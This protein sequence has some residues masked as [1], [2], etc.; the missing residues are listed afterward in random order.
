MVGDVN[1]FLPD[2]IDEDGECEIMI[3]GVLLPLKPY[4]GL[5]DEKT[6][7]IDAKDLLEKL[8][9]FCEIP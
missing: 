8:S 6:R 9:R 5:T 2:G 4:F 3:A 7:K 1:M